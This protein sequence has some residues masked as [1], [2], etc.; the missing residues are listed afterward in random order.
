MSSAELDRDRNRD[1]YGLSRPD[2]VEHRGGGFVTSAYG[3][4]TFGNNRYTPPSGY[5]NRDRISVGMFALCICKKNFVYKQNERE[6]RISFCV[7]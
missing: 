6:L 4:A 7:S 2:P 1:R 5:D 3:S